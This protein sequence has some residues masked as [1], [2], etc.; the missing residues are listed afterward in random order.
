MPHQTKIAIAT[1]IIA[2][3]VALAGV[4]LIKDRFFAAAFAVICLFV[5]QHIAGEAA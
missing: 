1:G 3:A 5:G 4:A 2:G